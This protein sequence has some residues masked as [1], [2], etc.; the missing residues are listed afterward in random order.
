MKKLFKNIYVPFLLMTLL[1]LAVT[2]CS[3]KLDA[4]QENIRKNETKVV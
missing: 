1:V 3:N 4:P 2:S